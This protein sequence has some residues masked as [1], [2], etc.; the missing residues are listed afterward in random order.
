ME[1]AKVATATTIDLQ[2]QHTVQDART[3]AA[4]LHGQRTQACNGMLGSRERKPN[5]EVAA[6]QDRRG[7]P[8]KSRHARAHAATLGAPT[9][10]LAGT[11]FNK[12]RH[13]RC[14]ICGDRA[15]CLGQY[16]LSSSSEARSKGETCQLEVSRCPTS[17]CFAVS[18]GMERG[19]TANCKRAETGSYNATTNATSNP[20]RQ[21]VK[22]KK[23]HHDVVEPACC[24]H[25]ATLRAPK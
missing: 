15:T 10:Q 24:P 23:T 1:Q 19:I 8:F 9:W 4:S 22:P 25:A 2:G 16:L 3:G 11:T 13:R 21:G 17:I 5:K 7:D 14:A 20:S 12:T 18:E 6:P